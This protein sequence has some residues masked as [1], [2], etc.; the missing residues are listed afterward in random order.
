MIE[1]EL[2]LELDSLNALL[3]GKVYDDIL[4]GIKNFALQNGYH[5]ILKSSNLKRNG[6]NVKE[7]HRRLEMASALYFDKSIDITKKV[8]LFLNK[9]YRDSK[10]NIKKK[11]GN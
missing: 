3:S 9:K 8:L 1:F 5:L 7:L 6:K 4:Q 11:N 10:I 2:K